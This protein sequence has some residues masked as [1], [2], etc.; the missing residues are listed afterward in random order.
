M[1]NFAWVHV[2]VEWSEVVLCWPQATTCILIV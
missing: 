1:W 2:S